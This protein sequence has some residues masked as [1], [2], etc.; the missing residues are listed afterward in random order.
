MPFRPSGVSI[1]IR[2]DLSEGAARSGTTLDIDS[3]VTK[4]GR[5]VTMS[6][7]GDIGFAKIDPN[8]TNEE[9]ISFTGIT[10]NTTYMTLTGVVWGY[11]FYNTTG[12]VSANQKRHTAGAE[13]IITNDDHW[14]TT[15]FVNVD[16]SQTISGEKTFSTV[17]KSTASPVS[18]DDITNKSYVDGVVAGSFPAERIAVAGIAGETIAD[19]D[20][21]YFDTVTNNKWMKCDAD[22]AA[23]VENVLL[24]IAQGAGTAGN[25]IDGGVLLNGLDDAQSG[26][27]VGDIMYASNTAGD[28][29]SSPGTKEV[30]VGIA[31]SATELYFHPRFPQHITEDE[32]DALVGTSGTPSASNK[33]VTA[34]D[35]TRNLGQVAYAEDGG[36]ND[37][38]AITLSPAPTAYTAGMTIAFK[39]NTANTGAATLN[40]NG[41]GA[42]TIVKDYNAT[43]DDNDIKAGQV[44][45][46]VYDGTNFQLQTPFP[47]VGTNDSV[48]TVT[49]QSTGAVDPQTLGTITMTGNTM[50]ANSI[51]RVVAFGNYTTGSAANYTVRVNFG[52][53]QVEV[54]T[55]NTTNEN[56]KIECDI[57]NQGSVN[58][59]KINSIGY[60]ATTIEGNNRTATSIDTSANVDITVTGGEDGAGTLTLDG[61][62][63][64]LIK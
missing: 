33:F 43:L 14:L 13:L 29:S 62:Y 41:L 18:A 10:D 34:N 51:L 8:N 21:V 57:A 26:M 40:V 32:Q 15:Q 12:G 56:W 38:Y 35:Q 30:A 53:V 2:E 1:R 37:N 25:A 44:V 4:D 47:P 11:N 23:S 52:G 39:A 48:G 27:T 50:D 61:F 28:I 42:K 17:P 31:K 7:I 24:G 19:G 9:I 58:S 55:G 60:R 22:T 64:Q 63:V 6:D 36:A 16:D 45:I 59:Q 49:N 54:I 5:R 20:L 3:I 46:V